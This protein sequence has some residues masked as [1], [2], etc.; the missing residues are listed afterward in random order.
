MSGLLLPASPWSR[1]CELAL[2]E[3]AGRPPPA[4]LGYASVLRLVEL[5]LDPGADV[6]RPRYVRCESDRRKDVKVVC[7]PGMVSFA[8]Q[9]HVRELY[10]SR[11]QRFALRPGICLLGRAL[12]LVSGIGER[13]D[14]RPFIELAHS[15]DNTLVNQ[16]SVDDLQRC[17]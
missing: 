1:D 5:T 12:R 6:P 4:A 9:R 13:E 15:L 7:L 3:K 17:R 10:A 2:R 8:I 14:D 11:K 16:R